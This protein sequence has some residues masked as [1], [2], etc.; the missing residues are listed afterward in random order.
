MRGKRIKKRKESYLNKIKIV[1][2]VFLIFKKGDLLKLWK[3]IYWMK[4]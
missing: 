1:K 3:I 4:K 2:I